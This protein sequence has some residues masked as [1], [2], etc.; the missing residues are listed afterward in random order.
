MPINLDWTRDP[1][2]ATITP[3]QQF[4]RH[5]DWS[6][7]DL[8]PMQTWRRELRQVVRFMIADTAPAILYW[9]PNSTIVYN[10]AYIPLVKERHPTMIGQNAPDV[11]PDFWNYFEEIIAKQHEDGITVSGEASLL[12]MERQ[13]GFLEE[14]YFDWKLVPVIGDDGLFLG[15]YGI[16]ADNTERVIGER[17]TLCVQ[18]LSQ[19]I[20]KTTSFDALWNHITLGLSEDSKDVPFALLFADQDALRARGT[21]PIYQTGNVKLVG[22]IGVPD[23]HRLKNLCW[24]T[25]ASGDGLPSA[26]MHAVQSS[27]IS[28]LS[29]DSAEVAQYLTGIDWKGS[30]VPCKQLAIMP[31]FVGARPLAVLVAGINP[32]RR[33]NDW[34]RDFL[35]HI[36]TLISTQLS[37]L[38]LSEELKYRAELASRAVKNFERSELRFERFAARS[39]VGLGVASMHGNVC[40]DSMRPGCLA[41][42]SRFYMPTMCGVSSLVS[43]RAKLSAVTSATRYMRMTYR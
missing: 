16:P 5:V 4:I 24:T 12:L 11:F 21:P 35:Q 9:G 31:I 28:I 43:T 29:T 20:A 39:M 7:T 13:T 42:D 1:I 33:Y 23:G 14:T 30:G 19:R 37:A 22:S 3:F 32:H 26:I 40:V 15:A 36:T 6:T 17:R 41:N 10:E 8:G 27:Q 25:E 2:P 38:R 18:N 34:Y